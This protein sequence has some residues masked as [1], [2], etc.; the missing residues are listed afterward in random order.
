[1]INGEIILKGKSPDVKLI[2]KLISKCNE[3]SVSLD[4]DRV[5]LVLDNEIH[6]SSDTETYVVPYSNRA[7]RG[8][9]I[10]FSQFDHN[11][12]VMALNL[13]S[14]KDTK[15]FELLY[16]FEMGRVYMNKE[17]EFSV[18]PVLCVASGLIGGKAKLKKVI[19]LLNDVL[20]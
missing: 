20:K 9:A 12:D 1:M 5:V 15:T 2:K 3:S 6:R 4:I 16:G 10:T 19:E 7:Y 8:K 13:Q 17:S 18:F 14:H 11:A